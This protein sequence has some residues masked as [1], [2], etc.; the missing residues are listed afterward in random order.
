MEDSSSTEDLKGGRVKNRR[1]LLELVRQ[2]G[3]MSRDDLV[4]KT[5]LSRATVSSLVSELGDRRLV[6]SED[7]Q[8]S[9][10]SRLASDPP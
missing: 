10:R 2:N 8:E 5:G 9:F 4:L 7:L 1:R 6:I 3:A